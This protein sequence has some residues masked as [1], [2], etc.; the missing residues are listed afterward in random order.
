MYGSC[1]FVHSCH[2]DIAWQ[3]LGDEQKFHAH[4]ARSSKSLI[5]T[6]EYAIKA[7]IQERT[8][9]TRS[10]IMHVVILNRNSFVER[11]FHLSHS[12]ESF[13]RVLQGD[14]A[15]A[16]LLFLSP[17]RDLMSIGSDGRMKIWSPRVSCETNH[18][19]HPMLWFLRSNGFYLTDF[20]PG[21][22]TFQSKECE[23]KQANLS[24]N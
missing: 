9:E 23:F 2:V 5:K 16:Q 18:S 3:N 4:R 1:D 8:P 21:N 17:T 14:C 7:W 11:F 19:F 13:S 12:S 15:N 10:L 22:E 6:N 24:L 20:A